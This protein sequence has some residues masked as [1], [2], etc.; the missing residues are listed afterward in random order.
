MNTLRSQPPLKGLADESRHIPQPIPPS[1]LA[2]SS[3]KPPVG[4]LVNTPRGVTGQ[5]GV[6]YDYVWAQN[7][8]FVQSQ[9]SLLTARILIA[10]F[11]TTGLAPAQEKLQLANGPI[12]ADIF[13][14]GLRWM[15]ETPGTER[16]FGV[17]WAENAYRLTLSAQAGTA[18]RVT[19]QPPGNPLIAEFH[20]HGPHEARFS[21]T[22]DQDE[23]AFRIYGV[24]G[25]TTSPDP[26]VKLRIGIYGHHR[27]IP[28]HHVFQQAQEQAP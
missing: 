16:F 1:S 13:R 9:S 11:R 4:Y 24:V 27:E 5:H 8:V 17:A 3:P 19:Y 25:P 15:L 22:D 2:R 14:Q 21:S 12:P 26:K 7:G 28:W 18:S 20:S 23:Q 6:A 10:T